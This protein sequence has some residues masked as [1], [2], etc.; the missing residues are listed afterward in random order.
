MGRGQVH[1]LPS[2]EIGRVFA[3]WRALSEHLRPSAEVKS[4]VEMAPC[5]CVSF[6][7]TDN[8]SH[9][10]NNSKFQVHVC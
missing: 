8:P 4:L 2:G 5:S 9:A 6:F 10:P 3:S 7:D 1:H